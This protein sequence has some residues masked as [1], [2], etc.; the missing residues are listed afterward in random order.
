MTAAT[1]PTRVDFADIP[2]EK[3]HADCRSTHDYHGVHYG[4]ALV[5]QR[6]LVQI[7]PLCSHLE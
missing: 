7:F 1:E 6:G 5:F 4:E 2:A 3:S